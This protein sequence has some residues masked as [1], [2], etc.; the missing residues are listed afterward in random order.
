[1][2]ISLNNV[3][4]P[5]AAVDTFLHKLFG[6]DRKTMQVRTEILAGLTTFLTMSYILAVN[7][8]VMSSTGMDRGALFTT[9][10]V[11]SII[12]TLVMAVYAKMP[13]ALAP[14]MGLNAVFAYT[15]CLGM[16]YSWRFALSAVFIEGLL[17][18]ILTV[19]NLREA[20]VNSLPPSLR[21]AI[22]GGIGLYLAF[23]GLQNGGVIVSR[24]ATL[25]MLGNITSGPGLLSLLGIVLTGLLLLW[26]VPGALLLGLLGTALAGVPLGITRFSGILSGPPSIA[27]IFCQMET[28]LPLIFSLD[29]AVVV[30][31]L[32]FIDLFDTLGM[33]MSLAP[34]A[35][36]LLP[37]GRIRGINRALMADAIGTTVGAVFGSS[38]VTSYL[39]SASGIAAGGR[40]GLTALTAAVGFMFALFF[41]PLFLAIP[42]AA[43]CP[44]L[45]IVGL[46]ALR[47]IKGID[48]QDDAE[49]IPAFL[50]MAFIPL[51]YSISDGIQ[52]GLISYVLL[53]LLRGNTGK[54]KP[55]MYVLTLVFVLRY[56][57][58][59]G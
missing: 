26:K 14:G 44:A 2:P 37:D 6:F 31:T 55:G 11:V 49:A 15:I 51:A 35:G 53:N 8:S 9:T 20:I 13:F 46:Y 4:T 1:M 48:L 17:F 27:P 41:A 32:L 12:A 59:P 22:G 18:I 45:V 39:E 30:F 5:F 54:L 40:S 10:A 38:T 56:I 43:T 3:C 29:M 50:C 47:S 36:L 57:F 52:L 28:E 23:I 42:G 24:E 21:C 19:T 34:Q 16:G 25:V 7:P 33:I 58:V